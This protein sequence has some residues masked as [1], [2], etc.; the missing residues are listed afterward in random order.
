M[1]DVGAPVERQRADRPAHGARA[2]GSRS[3]PATGAERGQILS[4]SAALVIFLFIVAA[5]TGTLPAGLQNSLADV[6]A[7][8]YLDV[9]HATSDDGGVTARQP[10]STTVPPGNAGA[11]V[12]TAPST[13]STTIDERGP[14]PT[15]APSST[16]TS[17]STTSTTRVTTTRP[18]P[19]DNPPPTDPPPSSSIVPYPSI[20]IPTTQPECTGPVVT[21]TDAQIQN[22]N[23]KIVQVTVRFDGDI[24]HMQAA[25]A[26]Q[27]FVSLTR[28]GQAYVGSVS[29]PTDVAP[30]T[31]VTILACS[32]S[33]NRTFPAVSQPVH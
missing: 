29:S 30:G 6:A 8:I 2:P 16:T 10:A 28:V 31:N 32:G 14:V 15:E 17:A 26:G 25:I 20:V 19:I 9:P 7:R 5:M 24:Q 18:P 33:V 4:L 1:A 13:T 23:K 3:A 27:N 22:A 21:Y 12:G 11:P